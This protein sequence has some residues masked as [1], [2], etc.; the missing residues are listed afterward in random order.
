MIVKDIERTDG[1]AREVSSPSMKR[2]KGGRDGSQSL[3]A[4]RKERSIFGMP[5][6]PV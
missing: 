4:Q 6:L 3:V 2:E 1:G 5:K